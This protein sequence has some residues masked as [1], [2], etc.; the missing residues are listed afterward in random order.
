MKPPFILPNV[1]VV[2][3]SDS[4]NNFNVLKRQ[5]TFNDIFNTYVMP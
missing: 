2:E 5:E 3:I 4:D 1:P